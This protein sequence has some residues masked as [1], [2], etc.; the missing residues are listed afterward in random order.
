MS[1]KIPQRM[2]VACREMKDKKD[3]IRIVKNSNGEIDIDFSYKANGR[4]AYICKSEECLKKCIKTKALNRALK[5]DI[6]ADIFEKIQ[7]NIG[8]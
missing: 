7:Q 4:G 2:C 1:K 6:K 3:L 8:V 5:S